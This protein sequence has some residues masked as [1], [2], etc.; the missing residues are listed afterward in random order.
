MKRKHRE[1]V[2]GTL[3]ILL[4][5]GAGVLP[6]ERVQAGGP[7]HLISPG[8]AYVWG[9]SPPAAPITPDTGALG[10]LDAATALS[11]LLAAAAAWEDIPS[12]SITLPNAGAENSITG[13]EGSGAYEVTKIMDFIQRC[14]SSLP[15]IN[16]MIFENEDTDSNGNG[17]IFDALGLSSGVLGF[18]GP[19][20]IS[21]TTILEGSAVFNGPA[22]RA[23]D[24]TGVNFRGV[25][26]H[27]LGHFLNLA[28]SV[29]NGQALFFGGSDSLFPD[30]TPLV[31]QTAD[32]ET[33]FPFVD[34]SQGGTGIGSST[35][36]Q[37][38]IAIASTLYPDPS[39][40]LS[41]FGTIKGTLS[42]AP[43]TP[44]TGG[45]IIARRAGNQYQDAVSAVSGDFLQADTPGAPLRGT[46]TLNTLT[47][48]ETYTLE[49]RDAVDGNFSTPVFVAP[50]GMAT[51]SLG[52]LPT[53]RVL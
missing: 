24:P 34:I 50:G 35:P 9:G 41:S 36:H 20:C 28:H 48:G 46:Y 44:R 19:D 23:D 43:S 25:M 30:G 37:D 10:I 5:G 47:P 2:G 31:P 39:V 32:V 1:I 7:I 8:V 16:P 4:L 18:A 40:P 6:I 17:D 12:S 21:A 26:T 33:M 45:Q 49:V 52:P 42:D 51:T 29:V 53:R 13:P 22:V 15:F 11:N 14:N 27:E 38:D 3:L